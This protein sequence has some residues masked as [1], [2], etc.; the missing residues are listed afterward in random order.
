MSSN[1]HPAAPALVPAPRLEVADI[2]RRF[3]QRYL[4]HH[5]VSY[6]G[7]KILRDIEYC[8]THQMGGHK[9]ACDTCSHETIAYNSCGNRHCPKCGVLNK[10][11]W[12][13]A[14]SAELLPVKYFHGVFTVPHALN[15]LIAYNK[16]IL[17]N[18]LFKAVRDTLNTF[19][20]DPKYELTGQWGCTMVLHTW[21]QKL[22]PHFHIHAVIP[23]GVYLKDK[24][25]WINAKYR[26]LYP[27]QA[28]SKVFRGK[29]VRAIRRRY[30]AGQLQFPGTIS[31]LSQKTAMAA[32]LSE[33][34][35][36]PWVVYCK[37]PFKSAKFVLDYLGRYTH[38]VAISN[39][40]LES[41]EHNTIT[42][43]Y[44]NRKKNYR[45]EYCQ[46]KSDQFIQRFLSHELPSGFMRIRHF[47]FLGNA[48][49]TKTLT[50]IRHLIGTAPTALKRKKR[51]ANEIMAALTGIDI[52]L[53]P[54]CMA[55]HL[56]LK[57]VIEK[58]R[59]IYR[60]AYYPEER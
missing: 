50:K 57:S 42:F 2:I 18:E 7:L 12:L 32:L 21:D 39:H 22:N 49:K 20:A 47:G 29:L 44:K 11:R 34:M 58:Q 54:K 9:R 40:R 60:Y 19:A 33:V 46:L 13:E 4:T 41:I 36:K 10:V 38:R 1:S 27:V 26:F 25:R 51:T 5:R 43:K 14:R 52:S 16:K 35:A 24:E 28:M 3:G 53:C 23:A 30:N 37:M 55:G 8:R 17:L 6:G 15:G 56:V 31:H 45:T 59:K 48:N